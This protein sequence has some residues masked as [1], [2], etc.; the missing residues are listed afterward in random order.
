ML[1]FEILFEVF[2]T[3]LHVFN[4]LLQVTDL[5]FQQFVFFLKAILESD[6]SLGAFLHFLNL[7]S[8]KG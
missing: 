4:R 5:V 1:V 6:L 7:K 2:L 8:F 3:L